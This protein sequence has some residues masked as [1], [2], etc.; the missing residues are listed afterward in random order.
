MAGNAWQRQTLLLISK[1][2]KRKKSLMT[3]KP[4]LC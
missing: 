2:L 4:G 1:N 3:L